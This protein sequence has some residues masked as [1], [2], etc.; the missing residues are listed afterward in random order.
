[1]NYVGKTFTYKRLPGETRW[2]HLEGMKFKVTKYVGGFGGHDY[3]AECA[4]PDFFG[5]FSCFWFSKEEIRHS[6][7]SIIDYYL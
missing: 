2:G 1:M 5:S 4:D 6:M 3:S 7:G